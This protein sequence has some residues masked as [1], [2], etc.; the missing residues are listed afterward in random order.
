V[1]RGLVFEK[2]TRPGIFQARQGDH[3]AQVVAHVCNGRG[4]YG[5]DEEQPDADIELAL[6]RRS[7]QAI[8]RLI[9]SAREL[10]S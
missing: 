2:T 7:D 1:S 6:A 8:A 5:F 3:T 4:V 10:G 9:Q